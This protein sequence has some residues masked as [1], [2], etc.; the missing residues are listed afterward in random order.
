M[1][2]TKIRITLVVWAPYLDLPNSIQTIVGHLYKWELERATGI[3]VEHSLV[4][5]EQS[6]RQYTP[7]LCCT[8][9]CIQ[10]GTVQIL[11]QELII[12][13]GPVISVKIWKKIIVAGKTPNRSQSRNWTFSQVAVWWIFVKVKRS[14]SLFFITS[15]S[16]IGKSHVHFITNV[17]TIFVAECKRR[18]QPASCISGIT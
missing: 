5:F 6:W 17:W 14:A 10:W 16:A 8:R 3:V 12:W 1:N 4:A 13:L 7:P 9:L 11:N 18:V 15:K 2:F